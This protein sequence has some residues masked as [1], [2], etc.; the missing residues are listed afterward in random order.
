MSVPIRIRRGSLKE[1]EN[2]DPILLS[3]ELSYDTT[4][5]KFKI[6]DGI[7]RWTKLAYLN[8]EVTYSQGSIV[9][10]GSTSGEGPL[11]EITIGSGLSLVDKTLTATGSASAETVEA[12][13]TI[14]YLMRTL[15]NRVLLTMMPST[16]GYIRIDISPNQVNANVTNLGGYNTANLVQVHH[17]MAFYTLRENISHAVLP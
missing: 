3:G 9:G 5:A 7:T 1:W 17:Q 12:L 16:G 8:D 13:E 6:G 15:A 14:R 4:S 2:V 11:E 10:R